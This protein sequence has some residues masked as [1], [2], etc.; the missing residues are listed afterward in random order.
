MCGGGGLVEN[1]LQLSASGH[2]EIQVTALVAPQ[3]VC[4]VK[5]LFEQAFLTGTVQQATCFVRHSMQKQ[6]EID[7]TVIP[8]VSF[9][10][11]LC[12]V[13]LG[14][15]P[16]F[17]TSAPG[18][19]SS[20]DCLSPLVPGVH[21]RTSVLGQDQAGPDVQPLT[22]PGAWT[23]QTL[24]LLQELSA[25]GEGPMTLPGQPA[26]QERPEPCPLGEL[27]QRDGPVTS[28]EGF[29]RSGDVAR[30]AREQPEQ[31]QHG[32]LQHQQQE[33]GWLS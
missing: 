26:L 18:Q 24:Q 17:P 20:P 27:R 15:C 3:H 4:H 30:P 10:A 9:G 1:V 7:I 14:P 19:S 28:P 11:R 13:V 16:T 5:N 2:K 31:R 22:V 21:S 29:A 33:R 8:L 32:E 25:S 12:T 6:S 23:S